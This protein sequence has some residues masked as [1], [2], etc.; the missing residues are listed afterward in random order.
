[1]GDA[2]FASGEITRQRNLTLKVLHCDKVFHSIREPQLL[3]GRVTW[4]IG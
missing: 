3:A 2:F 4:R 1:M